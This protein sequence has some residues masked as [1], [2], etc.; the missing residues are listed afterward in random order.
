MTCSLHIDSVY[1]HIYIYIFD[2]AYDFCV[3]C[4]HNRISYFIYLKQLF[5]IVVV[6]VYFFGSV[7]RFGV[8]LLLFTRRSNSIK[9][10]RE[11]VLLKWNY[12]IDV[13]ST[14]FH[15]LSMRRNS[16]IFFSNSISRT[17]RPK[18]KNNKNSR[19]EGEHTQSSFCVI[20]NNARKKNW[21]QHHIFRMHETIKITFVTRLSKKTKSDA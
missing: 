11:H 9:H 8:T 2:V 10:W 1:R 12:E 19:L 18:K 16:T 13:F 20:L 17:H 3:L 4:C 15:S 21:T 14:S 5:E 7:I 6:F